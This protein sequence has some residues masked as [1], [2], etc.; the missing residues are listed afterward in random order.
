MEKLHDQKN[1]WPPKEFIKMHKPPHNDM[2]E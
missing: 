2:D 1:P